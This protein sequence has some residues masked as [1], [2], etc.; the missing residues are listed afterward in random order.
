MNTGLKIVKENVLVEEDR[1]EIDKHINQ[2]IAKHKNNRYEINKLVFESVSVLTMSDNYSNQLASQGFLIRFWGGVTGKNRQLQ[3]KIDQ[4]LA[5]SQYA[6]QKTLEKLEEQNLMSFELITSV[7]N[8]LNSS[9]IEI[10]TEINNVYATL[11]TFFKKSKSDI[12]QLENRV[13]RLERNVSLL[14]WQNSIEYQMYDGV[15]YAELDDVTKLVCLVR[16][17]Y[18]ITK[19]NWTTSDLLLLKTAMTTIGIS[20][21]ETISYC[22]FIDQISENK[23][24]L[25]KLFDGIVLEGLEK[26]PEYIAVSAGIEKRHLLETKERYVVDNTAALMEKHGCLVEKTEIRDEMLK[27]YEAEQARIDINKEVS[28]YDLMMEILYNLEQIKE[29]QYVETLDVKMQEAKMLYSFYETD[30]LIPL[31][32]QLVHYGYAEAKYML[33]M[34]YMT[35]CKELEPDLEKTDE[36]LLECVNEGYAPA[37]VEYV[38]PIQVNFKNVKDISLINNDVVSKLKEMVE[39]EGDM[40]ASMEYGRCC[41]KLANLNLGENDYNV[42]IDMCKRG[43]V[44]YSFYEM[45]NIYEDKE[46]KQDTCKAFEYMEKAA[47]YNFNLAERS[48]GLKYEEGIGVKKDKKKAFELY[49]K[50]YEHRCIYSIIN[51]A[52]CYLYEGFGVALDK[53]KGYELLKEGTE[54]GAINSISGLAFA[55][56]NGEVNTENTEKAVLCYKKILREFSAAVSVFSVDAA[57]SLG[58]IYMSGEGNVAK[59]LEDA[60]KYFQMAADWEDEDA[61]KKLKELNREIS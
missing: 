59:N 15:E 48:L 54:K 34:L 10:E 37:V 57:Y 32:E 39:N 41:Q 22:N 11:V 29:I 25:V 9:I 2:I 43:P 47:K 17:F 3:T 55:Y 13:E 30:K 5:A 8:K 51:L 18:D 14:N 52:C 12:I 36:L 23:Q 50:S 38:M 53:E 45:A 56:R 24:L 26:Y 31:L 16:D 6:S 61:K 40:F 21:K 35:G 20:P 44:F 42:A 58:V 60:K 1:R 4:S 27:A 19:A 46:I 49:C 33:A 7:N 28:I